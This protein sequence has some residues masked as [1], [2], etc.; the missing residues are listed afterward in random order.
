VAPSDVL[1]LGA[2]RSLAVEAEAPHPMDGLQKNVS[3]R[4]VREA[5][6]RRSTHATAV[7]VLCTRAC[8]HCILFPRGKACLRSLTELCCNQQN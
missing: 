1:R 3:E 2:R 8:A 5:I 6:T 7:L 4:S